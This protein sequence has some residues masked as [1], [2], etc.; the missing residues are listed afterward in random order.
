MVGT[1]HDFSNKRDASCGSLISPGLS[2]TSSASSTA[3]HILLEFRLINISRRWDEVRDRLSRS[4]GWTYC[5]ICHSKVRIEMEWTIIEEQTSQNT[6][7]GIRRMFC[8][9]PSRPLRGRTA[10]DS[11]SSLL[12]DFEFRSVCSLFSL[13]GLTIV[14]ENWIFLESQN[15][16]FCNSRHER[17]FRQV[18]WFSCRLG[19]VCVPT[20]T[21]SL[22]LGAIKRWRGIFVRVL[23][24]AVWNFLVNVWRTRHG[25]VPVSQTRIHFQVVQQNNRIAV[26]IK[27]LVEFSEG[28]CS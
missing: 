2:G 18:N 17:T 10:F 27:F 28:H 24:R 15:H 6:S 23:F 12:W 21:S 14:D 26:G 25:W 16:L 13:S 11:F 20:I 8:S 9:L 7:G 5:I 3:F 19:L 4:N 22:H 1:W